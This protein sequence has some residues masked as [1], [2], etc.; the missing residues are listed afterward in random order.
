MVSAMKFKILFLLFTCTLTTAAPGFGQDTS[1]PES[2]RRMIE[3][4]QASTQFEQMARM[5][6]E[7][8]Y[9]EFLN[10]LSGDARHKSQVEAALVAVLSE[11]AELSARVTNG[12]ANTSDLAEI[13][14]PAYLRSRLAP[15]LSA[16]ELSLLD[17]RTGG[18]SAA[19]LKQQYAGELARV[20]NSLTASDQELVL[21]TIVKHLQI[22][23]SD[24]DTQRE[25]SVE[26]LVAKQ[27]QSFMQA[28]TELQ[29]RFTGE[30]LQDVFNFINQLQ[31][32]LYRN[33]S[34]SDA[35]Q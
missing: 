34:M 22:G 8:Q 6:V 26:E 32:N 30:K 21:D 23:S 1:V 3:Q 25:L 15:L 20:S 4:S 29:G 7:V 27:M 33:R 17:N 19:Q 12:L 10:A 31:S 16:G 2:V 5:Q 13:G 24:D 35:V 11:R 28:S 9:R 14:D 18:P